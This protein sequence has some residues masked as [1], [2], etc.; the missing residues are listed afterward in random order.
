MTMP[1]NVTE[2]LSVSVARQITRQSDAIWFSP[3]GAVRADLADQVL[4]RLAISTA[5]SEEPVGLLLRSEGPL[6]APARA[7]VA[8]LREAASKR[9]VDLR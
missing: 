3:A 8:I 1:S 2:T 6:S 4:L 5:G 9:R 7:F